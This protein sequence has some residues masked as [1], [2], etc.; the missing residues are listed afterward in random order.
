MAQNVFVFRVTMNDDQLLPAAVYA[1]GT[2]KEVACWVAI[3][4]WL[5]RLGI[6]YAHALA[7]FRRE[8]RY[9]LHV[10]EYLTSA[11]TNRP[12][13]DW[14]ADEPARAAPRI[15]DLGP[16][17]DWPELFNDPL[18]RAREGRLVRRLTVL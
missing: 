3:E 16:T 2:D 17:P 1:G 11:S 4:G 10:S 9:L 7:V 14:A 8:D 13:L 18:Y 12:F 5:K 15:I 6:N